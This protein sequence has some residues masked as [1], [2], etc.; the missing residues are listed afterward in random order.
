MVLEYLGWIRDVAIGGFDVGC[1]AVSFFTNLWS[2]PHPC[3]MLSPI[4]SSKDFLASMFAK[5][6]SAIAIFLASAASSSVVV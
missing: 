1:G 4:L 3:S 5:L 2:H 6:H